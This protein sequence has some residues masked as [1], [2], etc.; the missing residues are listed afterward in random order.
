MCYSRKTAI[1][2]FG[3]VPPCTTWFICQTIVDYLSLIVS[4]YV[5]N[6]S[7]SQWLLFDALNSA[8]TMSFSAEKVNLKPSFEFLMDDNLRIFFE[9]TNFASNIRL[10]MFGVLDSFLLFMKTYGE[11]N[12]HNM[13][14]LMHDPRFKSLQLVFSYVG[15]E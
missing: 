2:I 1:R 15:K 12:A 5:L 14:A 4:A 8:I 3:Q 11:K 10:E 6:Q 9:L 7:T 13:L